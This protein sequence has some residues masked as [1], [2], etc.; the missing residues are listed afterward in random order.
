MLFYKESNKERD[1]DCILSYYVA[2]ILK[3]NVKKKINGNG[4][5]FNLTQ[6]GIDSDIPIISSNI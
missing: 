1:N 3:R 6:I 2:L 4:K 5:H